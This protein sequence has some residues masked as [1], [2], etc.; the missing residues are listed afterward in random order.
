MQSQV[1]QGVFKKLDKDDME[2]GG[3]VNYIPMT[4]TFKIQE[5]C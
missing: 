4:E 5:C 3:P 2:Y 1:E